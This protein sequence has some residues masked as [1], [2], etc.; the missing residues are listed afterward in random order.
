M[1]GGGGA[2]ARAVLVCCACCT[3]LRSHHPRRAATHNASFVTSSAAMSKEQAAARA[4]TC[5]TKLLHKYLPPMEVEV[6]AKL[7]GTVE[8]RILVMNIRCL[9]NSLSLMVVDH[10]GRV[11]YASTQLATMLGYPVTALSGMTASVPGVRSRTSAATMAKNEPSRVGVKD[12]DLQAVV[13]PSLTHAFAIW[14]GSVSAGT[15]QRA[16]VIP[17]HRVILRDRCDRTRGRGA[18]HALIDRPTPARSLDAM[19]RRETDLRGG[20]ARR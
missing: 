18:S 2:R 13:E 11:S 12:L 20:K 19:E 17:A 7:G 16:E 1:G 15:S 4:F 9:T 5:R 8:Q 3:L 6:N 10:K 14:L